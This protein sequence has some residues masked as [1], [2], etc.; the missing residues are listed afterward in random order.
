MAPRSF[1]GQRGSIAA[2]QVAIVALVAAVIA[3]IWAIAVPDRVEE[4]GTQAVDCL[5]ASPSDECDLDADGGAA[6]GGGEGD[7]GGPDAG[8]SDTIPVA[9]ATPIGAAE[10]READTHDQ[11]RD[12]V[13]AL[14][15]LAD[16]DLP[17]LALWE[18]LQEIQERLRHPGGS[19]EQRAADLE[20]HEELRALRDAAP[21]G[22]LLAELRD[23]D[24]A[25]RDPVRSQE[26]TDRLLAVLDRIARA[27]HAAD[28]ADVL[29]GWAESGRRF[30]HLEVDLDDGT[31]R[32]AEVVRGDLDAADHVAVIVPGTGSDAQGF[33]RGTREHALALSETLELIPGGEDVAVVAC[34]CYAPPP[35]LLRAARS[36]HADA[37]GVDL[38]RII[39]DLPVGSDAQVHALGHSY[40]STALGR[41]VTREG[42]ELDSIVSLGG[43]GFGSGVS[44]VED[45]PE[46]AG[47]VWGI[48]HDLDP[49]DLAGMHGR[50]PDRDDF[51]AYGA[52]V[53]DG[54]LERR[55]WKPYIFDS[56]A[57]YYQDAESLRNLA[58]LV[59]GQHEQVS[60]YREGRR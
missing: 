59:S 33:D 48:R 8:G 12:E 55:W 3:A 58:L 4:A 32:V 57:I 54:D 34:L 43:P 27:E 46:T 30:V 49:I 28:L 45:V 36:G 6:A 10:Q 37:G 13:E 22:S 21:E 35:D 15:D 20:R 9:P 18:E 56:H 29:A 1:G 47:R 44:R 23:T 17:D 19:V 41:A 2:E 39:G 31:A 25:R 14:R 38:A 51:G 5:F 42:L 24:A 26:D 52:D 53:G 16:R 40:G 50:N 60:G 7:T 11:L